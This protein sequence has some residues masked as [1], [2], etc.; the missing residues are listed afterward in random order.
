MRYVH[1]THVRDTRCM[2][3]FVLI[4]LLVIPLVVALPSLPG[5]AGIENY[6]TLHIL[7]ETVSIIVSMLIFAVGLA[8]QRDN[9]SLR[10]RWL[11]YMFLGVAMLDFTHMLS[12]DGMPALV[13]ESGVEKSI[14]FWL[15]AR[16]FTA[17]ALIGAALIP[18]DAAPRR[19]P[20]SLPVFVLATVIL[21]HIWFLYFPQSVPRTFI[22]SEGLTP[23]KSGTEYALIAGYLV[24][25]VLF[26]RQLWAR[27]SRSSIALVGA[28]L[29]AAMAEYYFTLYVSVTDTYNLLGHIYKI[30]A[31]LFL[32]NGI[33]LTMVRAPYQ[34]VKTSQ[35]RLKATMDALP[36]LLLELDPKGTCLK[37]HSVGNSLSGPAAAQLVG[38]NI[39]DV[40]CDKAAATIRAAIG[41]VIRTG[42]NQSVQAR[43]ELGSEQ[44]DFEMSMAGVN[45]DEDEN[46]N[47]LVLAHDITEK[48]AR[49]AELVKLSTVLDR[50]PFPIIITDAQARIEY[51]NSAFTEI[52]GYSR[53]EA[54]GRNPGF[55]KSGSTPPDVYDAMWTQISQGHTWRGELSNQRK[56]G[57]EY[58]EYV[59]IHPVRDSTGKVTNYMAYK[60]DVTEKN[61]I[62]DQLLEATRFDKLTGLPNRTLLKSRFERAV[63][64][65][66][67]LNPSIILMFIDLDNFRVLNDALGW[68]SGDIVLRELG[69]RLQEA[70][71]PGNTLARDGGDK[72]VAFF[73]DLDAREAVAKAQELLEFA[74]RSLSYN[75]QELMLTCSIGIAC[76]PEDG[77][78]YADLQ[79]SAEAAMYA[80]KT[81]GRNRYRFFAPQLQAR[82]IRR[83]EVGNA[84]RLAL[85]R[86]EFHLVFQP[87]LSLQT[88]RCVGFEALL[89]WNHPTLGIVSPS[90][91]IAIAEHQGSM[92]AIGDW[93][94]HAAISQM[95]TLAEEGLPPLPVAINISAVQLNT[96]GLVESLE[97]IA[98]ESG[99]APELI[100]LELTEA[101][102]LHDPEHASRVIKNL[103]KVG[104]SIAIDDFGTGYSSFQHL[105][106]FNVQRLK[107]DMSFVRE[108]ETD[109][110]NRAIV[111]AIVQ[112]AHSLDLKAIAE[113]AETDGQKILLKEL[114][115]DELQGFV[116][117]KPL[118]P[119]ELAAFL[120]SQQ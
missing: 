110:R 5:A 1:Q 60:E 108:L 88:G 25:A 98:R 57:S 106:R 8:T 89:R 66:G 81:D 12:F 59:H 107:I 16:A 71:G 55:L 67:S 40:T 103:R 35:S 54:L 13:T 91:F 63:E 97:N 99:I 38:A 87:K 95:R 70:V 21:L 52:S 53:E 7:L 65:T 62:A 120:S 102:A 36:D 49:D 104:F 48:I 28:A 41:N 37:V 45:A 77:A 24:A 29:T 11:A 105:K 34:A 14:N 26:F 50:S 19:W 17:V 96:R 80:A 2:L 3:G 119:E 93:V 69:T 51:V 61:A 86:S 42:S 10:A 33:F 64:G 116:Y 101:A 31:Y 111:S 4:L 74:N 90:E 44:R 109:P 92:S 84:L 30:I 47:L 83:H 72:F 15:S 79:T 114:G 118:L 76:Y 94:I 73:P 113:G 23:F 20:Y 9:P 68:S 43:L 117:A 56:D 27:A 82:A 22:E 75:A 115:C 6:V 32:Y 100:E 85:E 39:F 78:T 58:T 46:C 18:E 112:L